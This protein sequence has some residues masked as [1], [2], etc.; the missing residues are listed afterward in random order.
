M[1]GLAVDHDLV[2]LRLGEAEGLKSIKVDVKVF[3]GVLHVRFCDFRVHSNK[4][5]E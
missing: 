4:L 1:H 5:N 2:E 3:H